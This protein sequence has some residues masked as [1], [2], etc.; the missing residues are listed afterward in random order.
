MPSKEKFHS[1]LTGK[2]ISDNEYKHVPKVWNKFEMK[3]MKDYHDLRLKFD[4]L[5][6]SDV[7]EK[8]KNNSLNIYGLCPSHYLNAPASGWDAMLNK[9]IV[10][11][12]LISDTD[13]YLFFEKSMRGGVSYISMVK[14]RINIKNLMIQNNNQNTLFI[15]NKII[16]MVMRCLNFFQVANSNALILKI[17]I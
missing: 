13:M 2:E 5:L 15:W 11:H 6:L 7:F 8:F 16:Y 1:S 3:T 14:P 9:T 4:V 10:E 12:K 17:L